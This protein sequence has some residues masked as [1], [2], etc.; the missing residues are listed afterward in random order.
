MEAL[1]LR[2]GA[3][4]GEQALLWWKTRRSNDGW[5]F[6]FGAARKRGAAWYSA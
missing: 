4:K 2:G 1:R 6:G 3:G 5:G